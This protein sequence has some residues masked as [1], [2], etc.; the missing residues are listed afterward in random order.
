MRYAE[1]RPVAYAESHTA[2][3]FLEGPED[4]AVYGAT[5]DRLAALALD[6]GQSR[7]F[8]A[9]LASEYDPPEEGNDEH[10]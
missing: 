3:V 7:E 4:V 8:L 1:H 6:G 9:R 2:S 10:A 5:L